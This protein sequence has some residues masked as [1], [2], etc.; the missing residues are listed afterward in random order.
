M[1]DEQKDSLKKLI[2]QEIED[3][4]K[5]IKWV[6]ESVQPVVPDNAIGRLT[7]MEA[8]NS[9]GINEANLR[10]AKSKLSKLEKTLL[11]ID[12]PEFGICI[13]CDK[14]I[15]AGRLMAMPES[16]MCVTCIGK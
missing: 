8:I 15:P 14:P 1:D 16:S 6:G 2:K 10:S 9:K 11:E 7:R 5:T 4:N 3:L 12:Q 13:K